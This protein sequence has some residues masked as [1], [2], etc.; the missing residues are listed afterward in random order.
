MEEERKFTPEGAEDFVAPV[1]GESN[2]EQEGSDPTPQEIFDFLRS[3]YRE[4]FDQE[5]IDDLAEQFEGD[6]DD[7]CGYIVAIL[8]ENGISEEEYDQLRLE[9]GLINSVDPFTLS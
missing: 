8:I 3:N 2:V 5:A 1:S 9:K 7:A 4:I 6:Y